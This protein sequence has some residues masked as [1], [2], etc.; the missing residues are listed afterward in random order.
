MSAALAGLPTYDLGPGRST[1]ELVVNVIIYAVVGT[2]LLAL[3]WIGWLICRAVLEERV[4][5]EVAERS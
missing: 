2:A 3:A 5:R 4:R 1:D